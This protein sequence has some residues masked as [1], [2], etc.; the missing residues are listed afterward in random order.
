MNILILNWRD[1]KNPMAG[2]AEY[3][4]MQHA[5]S[6]A[7]RGHTVTWF[8]AS[9]PGAPRQE[10][11]AGVRFVRRGNSLTV[12]VRAP[13]FYWRSPASYDVVIDEIHGL[14]FFTPLFVRGRK[15]A[16]IHEIAGEIWNSMHTFPW[17][18]IGRMLETMYLKLYSHMTFW[19]DAPS[20]VTELVQKGIPEHQCVAIPCAIS[21]R[22]VSTFPKK[23][24]IPTFLVVSRLVKMKGVEDVI[25]AYALIRQNIGR[26]QLWIVGSGEQRYVSKLKALASLHQL[27]G[28]ISF[29]DRVSEKKKLM[30]MGS[31]HVLLHASI[32]EG[33]GLVVLE[34]ASQG[35]PS[36]VYDVPGLRDTV[37][38]NKTGVI[39]AKNSPQIM[40]QSAL[41]MLADKKQYASF[42]REGAAWVK[43]L[44]WDDLTRKSLALLESV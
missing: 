17:N 13:F 6:W 7:R 25:T 15:I 12:Y 28:S 26:S 43:S 42:Q 21:N 34:A 29:F 31:A 24:S 4:T 27:K 22:V 1:P 5:Q 3:V 37:Q 2:G 32:K 35:T 33:W 20:T 8:T 30:L 9:Y 40:A 41:Q 23:E 18:V 36:V 11:V 14:P 16:F 19:T 44:R 38:H 39:V 10:T